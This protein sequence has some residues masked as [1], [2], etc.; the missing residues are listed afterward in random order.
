MHHLI[1]CYIKYGGKYCNIF[2][3]SKIRIITTM[4]M[5]L[6]VFQNVMPCSQIK[7]CRCFRVSCCLHHQ[8][9]WMEAAGSSGNFY[10]P[11]WQH[12]TEHSKFHPQ[13]ASELPNYIFFISGLLQKTQEVSISIRH[14]SVTSVLAKDYGVP[15]VWLSSKSSCS[16]FERSHSQ[17]W[18]PSPFQFIIH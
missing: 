14:Q 11:T 16:V 3:T 2:N 13:Y 5:K 18:P 7:I 12:I 15:T 8:G 10:Q 17:I 4:T 6:T 9:T 1:S